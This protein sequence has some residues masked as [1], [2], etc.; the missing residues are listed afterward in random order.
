ME[1]W[2]ESMRGDIEVVCSLAE[3]CGTQPDI[4]GCTSQLLSLLGKT[5]QKTVPLEFHVAICNAS[6]TLSRALL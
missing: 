5:L 1:L 4:S 6:P 2:E 3:A